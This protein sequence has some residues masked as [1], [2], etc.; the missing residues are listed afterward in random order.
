M[1]PITGN[2]VGPGGAGAPV[3]DLVDWFHRKHNSRIQSSE[4][5]TE[6]MVS[7][8]TQDPRSDDVF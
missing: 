5:H 6:K 1:F 3:E 7:S 2:G 4:M 8:I